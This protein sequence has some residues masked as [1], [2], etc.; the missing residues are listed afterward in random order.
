MIHPRCFFLLFCLFPLLVVAQTNA[1]YQKKYQAGKQLVA[2]GKYTQ[3]R[4]ALRPVLRV[5]P[6]NAYSAYAHYFTALA[7]FKNKQPLEAKQMLTTLQQKFPTWKQLD[8]VRYLLANIS[9]DEAD[10]AGAFGALK[11]IRS[12]A[13]KPA[14]AGLK[15]Y[16]FEQIKDLST[17]KKLQTTYPDDAVLA[18]VLVDRL[19][20]TQPAKEDKT[21]ADR[22][23]KQFRIERQAKVEEKPVVEVKKTGYNVAVLFPFQVDQ[24]NPGI[25][26]RS[27]QFALDMYE[28]IKLGK[29]KLAESGVQINLFAYDIAND[30]NKALDLVNSPEFASM[31]LLIGPLYAETNKVVSTF[32]SAN[33]IALI[34]PISYNQKI[35]QDNP[36]SFLVQTSPELRAA[37]AAEYATKNFQPNS[38]LIFYGTAPDDSLMAYAYRDQVKASG[39]KVLILKKMTNAQFGTSL[40]W[41]KSG[42]V[43]HIFL[44]TANQSVATTFMSALAVAD[45]KVPVITNPNLFDFPMVGYDQYEQRNVHFIYPEYVNHASDSVKTFSNRYITKN[46]IIPSLY[47]Y[48]GYDLTVFFGQLLGKFGVHFDAELH[49][50]PATKAMTLSGFD[51]TGSSNANQYVPLLK[52]VQSSLVPVTRVE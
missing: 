33:Q 18:E 26:S 39:G 12:E 29:E 24:L 15:K 50:L 35:L 45:S 46:N 38:A 20:V 43:G 28:G 13:M 16:Y 51:Y 9:L 31:D 52:F 11:A 5:S 42:T 48:Q 10:Y 23:Q 21:L 37:K 1:D 27:N 2:D 25:P 8:E 34:N 22:L 44:A 41:V 47:S 19:L 49:R 4:E 30:A 32:A 6:A 36:H 3:A 40:Q 14:V 17:L 7:S